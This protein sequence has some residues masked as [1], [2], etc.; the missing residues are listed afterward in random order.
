[1]TLKN[2]A[3]RALVA[4]FGIPLLL[5]TFYHGSYPLLVIVLIINVFSQYELYKL[6]EKKNA[7]P[8]KYFG[9]II[10]I[11][12]TL[13]FFYRGIEKL[14]IVLLSGIIII[15]LIELFRNKPNAT[16]NVSSTIAGILY[17]TTLFSFV[18]LMRELPKSINV[19][20]N[21]GGLWL[22]LTII[23]IWIC[24]TAAYF[25]GSAIGKHKLFKRVSP[26]KTIEGA[27][28]GFVFSLIT[29]YVFYL[30]YPTLFTLT[31]YLIIG[32]IIG[33]ASQVGDLIES[34]FK[35]D[36]GVKDSSAILPGHGGFLDRFDAPTFTVPIIYFYISFIVLA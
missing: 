20:Y 5:F 33:I 8:L 26:H 6:A 14:W 30:L 9:I 31:H 34:L 22:I 18:I 17:P 19:A 7:L 24:D 36:V 27:L 35:R 3:L 25:V 29:V 11:I 28:A 12:V 2:L 4:I 23:T 16:L 32:G 15:L 21:L 13:T 10:G 1:M